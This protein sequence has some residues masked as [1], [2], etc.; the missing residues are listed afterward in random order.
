MHVYVWKRTPSLIIKNS[1]FIFLHRECRQFV[2]QQFFCRPSYML[3]CLTPKMQ[4]MYKSTMSRFSSL[5]EVQKFT[6]DAIQP[7]KL[8]YLSVY[9]GSVSQVHLFYYI[10]F[11]PKRTT[12]NIPWQDLLWIANNLSS[13][14]K[15]VSIS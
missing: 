6:N 5:R 11:S 9:F 3:Y 4:Y 8:A 1:S 13:F 14:C 10:S 7:K 2:Q 15:C 12:P